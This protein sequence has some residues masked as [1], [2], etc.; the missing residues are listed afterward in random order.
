MTYIVKWFCFAADKEMSIEVARPREAMK[1]VKGLRVMDLAGQVSFIEH[2]LQFGDWCNEDELIARL[3]K[4]YHNRYGSLGEQDTVKQ[5]LADWRNNFRSTNI[6]D[7]V[8]SL[9]MDRSL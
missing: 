1:V 2:D 5:E 9:L 8:G 6:S 3:K 7:N 4:T